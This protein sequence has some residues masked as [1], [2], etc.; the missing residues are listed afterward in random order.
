MNNTNIKKQNSLKIAWVFPSLS[1]GAY[2][3][4]IL[5]EF[6]TKF[7]NTIVYSGIWE[8]YLPN[9]KNSFKVKVVG[10][11]KLLKYGKSKTGYDSVIV[12]P[13]LAII[14]YIF[15]FKPNVVFASAFSLWSLLVVLMKPLFEYKIIILYDGSSPDVDAVNSKVK[16]LFRKFIIYFSHAIVTNSKAGKNYFTKY[17]HINPNF[18]H[19]EP[20]L[21]PNKEL[22]KYD[23]EKKEMKNG[24]FTI[25][26]VGRL[27]KGKGL[28]F[29]I[30]SLRLLKENGFKNFKC[31]I[32]GDGPEIENINKMIKKFN[33][34]SNVELVGWVKTYELAKYYSIA[35]VFVSSTLADV[36]GMTVLEAMVFG[37][38]V[39]CSKYA[40][41]SE[42][43]AET[44]CG[45]VFDPYQPEELTNI[46]MEFINN[47][48]K[49]YFMGQN[50][51]SFIE[52]NNKNVVVNRFINILKKID[53]L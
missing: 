45:F 33:L 24:C 50:S 41:V 23:F 39:I 49:I 51:K 46:F 26:S 2:W 43:I 8:G 16:T 15:K 22:F 4:P 14:R 32:V 40:N 3:Q 17:L 44:N 25:L 37:K 5:A 10:N 6:T 28:N 19:V 29:L 1:R 12:L 18:V 47:P 30:D 36:W 27:I 35:D 20:Y 21:I 48:D 52:R 38:P 11:T 9:Y 42:I 13:S 31:M 34:E 53:A 7:P